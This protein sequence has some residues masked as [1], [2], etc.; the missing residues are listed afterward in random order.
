MWHS[1]V[2]RFNIK[3]EENKIISLYVNNYL[4][5]ADICYYIYCISCNRLMFIFVE[6]KNDLTFPNKSG[7]SFPYMSLFTNTHTLQ[8][9][10]VNI[11]RLKIYITYIF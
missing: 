5:I 1:Y 4:Y 3:I 2:I 8:V 6:N 9:C 10:R 7:Q 11:R